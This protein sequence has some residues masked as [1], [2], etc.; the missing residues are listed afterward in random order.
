MKK[1]DIILFDL[2]GTLTDPARGLVSGFV[3]ALS[4]VGVPREKF[5]DLRRFIGPPLYEEWQSEFGF[6]AEESAHA[7]DVFREYYDI[8]GWWDNELY[9]G[10]REML[11]SLRASG[12]KIALATS[13]PEV[14]ARKVL[15]LFDLTRYFDFI[16]GAVSGTD[17]H[18]KS[19]VI[20]Y[21]LENLVAR[22]NLSRVILVGD[23]KYDSEGAAECGI[24]SLGVL[25]GH[26]TEQELRSC[27]FTYVDKTPTDVVKRLLI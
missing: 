21:C 6:T 7:I 23:R 14:T 24:D 19:Q 4:K 26:G 3:Y 10:V 27:G 17:R 1:Y 15:D 11:E 8:Y 12:K 9:T 22:E 5:G 16:A 18:R 25:W 2:D 13:K 20:D